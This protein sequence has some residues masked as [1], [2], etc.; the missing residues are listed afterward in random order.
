[1]NKFLTATAALA[2]L[3][4]VHG[5][6]P[7][8]TAGDAGIRVNTPTTSVSTPDTVNINGGSPTVNPR[9]GPLPRTS[10]GTPDARGGTLTDSLR[11]R[12]AFPSSRDWETGS[13]INQQPRRLTPLPDRTL[14]NVT[15]PNDTIEGAGSTIRGGS[16]T[17]PTSPT[18]NSQT[19][20]VAP[21]SPTLNST[22]TGIAPTSPLPPMR[23]DL[24]AT[25][26]NTP[27]RA[28]EQPLDQALSAK[29]R[30]E[31]S[32]TP[33]RGMRLSPETVRDLRI[34]SQG[35]RLI[36]EGNVNSLAE[37]Q[38]VEAQARRVPGV[39]AID[40]RVNVSNR[41]LGAPAAG[42]VGQSRQNSSDL[43]EESPSAGGPG[44][45]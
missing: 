16:T 33:A 23:S 30:A 14:P 44:L 21:T 34:T 37:K 11:D 38:L 25:G 5:Q 29:V 35:G 15:L 10:V 20:G 12:T 28:N 6:V 42:Q 26:V 22:T 39:I 13:D 41:G 8:T 4:A 32:Q 9:S 17:I 45:K 1:M 27:P 31:L 18:L 24:N 2:A 43:N 40:N 19:T 3:T 7:R 36:L